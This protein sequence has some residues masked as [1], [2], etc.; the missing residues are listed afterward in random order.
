M[1][2]DGLLPQGG[3]PLQHRNHQRDT[4]MGTGTQPWHVKLCHGILMEGWGGV[5]DG[6]GPL[7]DG[8][9]DLSHKV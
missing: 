1:A 4:E 5:G 7:L 8:S 3:T 6:S 9:D 2:L